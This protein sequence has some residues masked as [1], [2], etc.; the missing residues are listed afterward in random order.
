MPTFAQGSRSQ[1]AFAKEST[2]GTAVTV[3]TNLPF[4][5]HSLTLNKERVAGNEIQKDR[6]DRVDRHG[7]VSA[8]GDIVVDLRHGT[9]DEL[10]ASAMLSSADLS[11]AFDG[12]GESLSIGT[13][14]RFFT[15]EDQMADI[16]K[17]RK[18]TSMHVNSMG[19]SI[20][21]NQMVQATFGMLG[22]TMTSN[23]TPTSIAAADVEAAP[24]DSYNGS[25]SI[26]GS[27]V[28]IITAIDFTV[29]NNYANNFVVGSNTAPVISA[30]KAVV[31]GTVSAYVE[32]TTVLH[33]LFVDETE[34][35]ISV[36]VKDNTTTPDGL[37]FDM[38]RVKFNGA[39]LPVSGGDARI[40]TLPFIALYD[41]TDNTSFKVTKVVGS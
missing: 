16:N 12:D 41:A 8:S 2:Y 39:D 37:T 21:P 34:S 15:I 17:A 35:S 38:P 7:N 40:V 23:Q 32:N 13:A 14:N 36:T 6:M 28:S 9:Y 20:A 29:T 22:Q 3:T 1:L 25:I 30:G 11:S 31:E 24:F 5:T 18:F 27:A 26:G 10:I 4:N 19:I 33:D